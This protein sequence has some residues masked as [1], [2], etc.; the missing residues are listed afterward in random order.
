MSFSNTEVKLVRSAI[1][2]FPPEH[3]LLFLLPE[4][5]LPME[6]PFTVTASFMAQERVDKVT[7]WDKRGKHD[8]KVV[9]APW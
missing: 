5:G 9:Q 6:K 2:L 1:T 4:I 8:V 3:V 7:V